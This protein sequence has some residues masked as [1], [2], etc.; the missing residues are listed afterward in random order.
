[1]KISKRRIFI[2]FPSPFF[3]YSAYTAVLKHYNNRYTYTIR[4]FRYRESP[5]SPRSAR[6]VRIRILCED[7][8]D[9]MCLCGEQTL[10]SAAGYLRGV[11]FGINLIPRSRVQTRVIDS[12]Y[13]VL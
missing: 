10:N 13:Y 11:L 4:G 3:H 6:I 7:V 8:L 5:R 2:T 9:A 1:M 12:V